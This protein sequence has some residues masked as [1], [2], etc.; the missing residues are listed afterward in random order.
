MNAQKHVSS[1]GNA[2]AR[3]F[4]F[5]FERLV[6]EKHSIAVAL[7]G[8]STPKL[9]F[10]ILA[11]DFKDKIDWTRIHFYWGDERCVPPDDLESNYK[12]TFDHL[13]QKV[14]IPEKN[15]HRVRGEDDPHKEA[16]RYSEHIE[17]N[18]KE[19][20]GLAMGS[21]KREIVSTVDVMETDLCG[22]CLYGINEFIIFWSLAASI[23]L[24]SS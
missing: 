9:L 6:D 23:T 21:R 14:N 1:D 4:A 16:I 13:F 15:I 7:S 10:D 5:F 24:V 19:A 20:H 11:S 18:L 22:D 12:M 3:E 8:G 2:V 17:S